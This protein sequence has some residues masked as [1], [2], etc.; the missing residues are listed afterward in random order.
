MVGD[1]GGA[2]GTRSECASVSTVSG[3]SA[4]RALDV[5]GGGLRGCIYGSGLGARGGT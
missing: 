1:G 2:L 3:R 5:L 4:S